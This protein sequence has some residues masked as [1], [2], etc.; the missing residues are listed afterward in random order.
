MSAR[1]RDPRV[2]ASRLRSSESSREEVEVGM[3]R[4]RWRTGA[5]V[6]A[7][8]VGLF[9]LPGVAAADPGNGKGRGPNVPDVEW[10]MTTYGEDGEV[11]SVR[12]GT[13]PA[14]SRDE[15][16][17]ASL[18]GCRQ[19]DVA[20]TG[21]TALGLVAYRYHQVK[22]W[23]WSFPHITSVGVGSYISNVTL[24]YYFRGDVGS[25]EYFYPLWGSGRGGHYSF[26]QGMVENCIF[27]YG[28]IKTEYPWVEIYINADGW[29]LHG[30]G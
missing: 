13:G 6:A 20:Q 24:N 21:R 4:S 12:K 26:R 3:H 23:C 14:P 17:V 28:C 11:V 10:T 8:L 9:A 25:W 2:T 22:H 1:I 27:R 19:V 30:H 29:W 16:R 7:A 5:V 18:S 15:V